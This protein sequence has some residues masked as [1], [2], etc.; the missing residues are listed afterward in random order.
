MGK[1]ERIHNVLIIFMVLFILTFSFYMNFSMCY[2]QSSSSSNKVEY[3]WYTWDKIL[4]NVFKRGTEK[5]T[6]F[7]KLSPSNIYESLEQPLDKSK[8]LLFYILPS[9]LLTFILVYLVLDE[10]EIFTNKNLIMSLSAVIAFISL[11]TGLVG[12]AAFVVSNFIALGILILFLALVYLG[13]GYLYRKKLEEWGYD[14]IESNLFY[15][16]ITHIP[17]IAA[18]A[19]IFSTIWWV[20]FGEIPWSGPGGIVIGA[21][22]GGLLLS[23]RID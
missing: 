8:D 5:N 16:F 6:L 9:F 20:I 23:L 21:A 15:I 2:A 18:S 4:D 12:Y 7:D 3:I 1:F 13:I 19:I 22:V 14:I 17:L 10:I 11:I